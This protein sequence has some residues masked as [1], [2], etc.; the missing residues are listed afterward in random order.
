MAW[1]HSKD[2]QP[3]PSGGLR[4]RRLSSAKT[5][6]TNSSATERSEE[7]T[8]KTP[9]VSA[10]SDQHVY[11]VPISTEDTVSYPSDDHSRSAIYSMLAQPANVPQELPAGD[12]E[13]AGFDD[14]WDIMATCPSSSK[15]N[16]MSPAA[17]HNSFSDG[18]D[19][20]SSEHAL[21]YLSTAFQ[22][23]L[24]KVDEEHSLSLP[25]KLE[26]SPDFIKEATTSPLNDFVSHG[27]INDLI[28]GLSDP[29]PPASETLK[30]LPAEGVNE[31]ALLEPHTS[32]VLQ[33]Y[34]FT[35]EENS[36][37]CAV[38][39]KELLITS[40]V[41]TYPLPPSSDA[42]IVNIDSVNP[43]WSL[44]L[45]LYGNRVEE[46]EL[47]KFHIPGESATPFNV[48][49]PL[50]CPPEVNSTECCLGTLEFSLCSQEAEK[51]EG[52]GGFSF[53]DDNPELN[54]LSS[55]ELVVESGEDAIEKE[56][57]ELNT[58]EENAFRVNMEEE[59]LHGPL[60][61]STGTREQCLEASGVSS[62]IQ[63]T[64]AGE[65][66]GIINFVTANPELM[67]PPSPE[68]L[69]ED[70]E[71]F[72][73]DKTSD[74]HLP[75]QNDTPFNFKKEPILD[76]L[77]EDA[78]GHLLVTPLHS[79]EIEIT[80]VHDVVKEDIFE[81]EGD[82]AF[83]HRELVVT[84]S[85]ED[86][87]TRF[88]L[89]EV[90]PC[91]PSVNSIEHC[92]GTPEVSLCSQETEN[93][94]GAGN[95]SFID[96]NP[97]L[98]F[99]SSPELVVEV[100]EDAIEVKSRE[101]NTK[102]ENAILINTEE[103]A[104]QDPLIVSI[105]TRERCLEASDVPSCIQD[106]KAREV[107]GIINFVTA[108]PELMY[109]PSPELRAEDDEDFEEDKM[110]DLHLP[111]QNGL[112]LNIEKEPVLDS[113]VADT[114][115][116]L[117]VTPLYNEITE[118]HDVV[119]EGIFDSE[120]E[121]TFNHRKLAVTPS[122]DDSNTQNFTS[123]SMPVQFILN[124]DRNEFLQ[125][126]Q[127]AFSEP[128]HQSTRHSEGLFL[129]SGGRNNDEVYSSNSNVYAN[130][131][132]DEE[133]FAGQEGLPKFQ[134]EMPITFSDSPIFLDEVKSA[135]IV[136]SDAASPK[137]SLQ[138]DLHGGGVEENEL[139]KYHVPEEIRTPF[140]LEEE[141]VLSPLAVNNGS[142]FKQLKF[143]CESAGTPD[144]SVCNQETD[145]MEV[146]GS[147]S[148]AKASPE[149]SF[150]SS[151]ELVADGGEDTREKGTDEL[152]TKEENETLI[153]LEDE[154]LQGE[155]VVS[156][157]D[158][159]L[160]TSEFSLSSQGAKT[161]E[162]PEIVSFVTVSPELNYSAFPDLHAERDE[163]F[164]VDGMSDLLLEQKGLP[165]NLGKEPF[166]DPL[167]VDTAE[168]V[169]TSELL[170]CSEEVKMTEVH[171][172][173]KEVL[174]ESEDVGAFDHQKLVPISPDDD[175]T[176][177]N[178]INNSASAQ[179]ISDTSVHETSQAG[180]EVL[181]ESPH[182]STFHSEGIFFSSGGFNHDEGKVEVPFAGQ[183]GLSNSEDEMALTPL[184]TSIMLDEVAS[185]ENLTDNS[186]SS[187]SVPDSSHI[188]SLHNHE[189]ASSEASQEAIFLLEGSHT[190]SDEGINSEIFSLYSRSSSCVSE[191]NM[192]ETLRGSTSSEPP[193]DRDLSFE[194]RNPVTFPNV[195][196][197]ESNTN[198]PVTFEFILESNMIETLNDAEEATV[199]SPHEVSSNFLGTFVAPDVINGMKESDKHLELSSS[200]FAPVVDA[201]ESL[202]TG[203]G[204]S[205]PQFENE[206]AVQ[207]TP[208]S[209]KDVNDA[210]NSVTNAVGGP[211]DNERTSIVA[212]QD[213]DILTLHRAYMSPE[214]VSDDENSLADDY[215]SN[216]PHTV[217]SHFF[218]ENLS[219]ESQD[220]LSSEEILV[221]PDKGSNSGNDV[222]SAN[223]SLRSTVVNL[224]EPC[225]IDQEGTQQ[226]DE[227]MLGIEDNS[228]SLDIPDVVMADSRGAEIL[229][230][231]IL[232][233]GMSSFEGTLI[234]LD[235]DN[236]A[237]EDSPNNSGSFMHTAQINTQSLLGLQEGSFKPEEEI[238]INS[239]TPYEIDTEETSSS[240]RHNFSSASS[241][242]DISFMEAPQA[243]DCPIN[244]GREKVFPKDKE[245]KDGESKDMKEDV[246]DLDDG[247]EDNPI[248]IF[249]VDEITAALAPKPYVELYANDAS[250]RDPAMGTSNDYDMAIVSGFQ[251][252]K[253]VVAVINSNGNSTMSE[254]AD[255][256]YTGSVDDDTETL[257]SSVATD[258]QS[259]SNDMTARVSVEWPTTE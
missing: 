55:P 181:S 15:E 47:S 199:G 9:S 54:F 242:H 99:L 66:P 14:S 171:G 24:V 92:L 253:P 133:P 233:D 81:S 87:M 203:L 179:F 240:N 248:D 205:E 77:V 38:D 122:D 45:E 115:E 247:H 107:P 4:L 100:G 124:T 65:V 127:E 236:N 1:G 50:L 258:T 20:R 201:F 136:D 62:C 211:E 49:E 178:L 78:S 237:E 39:D 140:N 71:E 126:G 141:V 187:L 214:D 118:V 22:E 165:I 184:D 256:Q 137:L 200:S 105:C 36:T 259:I 25:E 28:P 33:L 154:A 227:T 125:G 110:S 239:V 192:P 243:Q 250:S 175:S 224:A 32:S 166:L 35:S 18:D 202:Q 21:S 113:P 162:V 148:F 59:A 213:G 27:S 251:Q 170:V 58:K 158:Q 76:S 7:K 95:F 117:L 219:P 72:K 103:E 98:G 101:L 104:L 70:D 112:P 223:S 119:K 51:L 222:S 132:E 31:K 73:E 142:L 52:A 108:N 64:K 145:E 17:P 37:S 135:A 84:H 197:T 234:S 195:D 212:L 114:A 93:L 167:V 29:V 86:S 91:P 83:N 3:A 60:I 172:V 159:S 226:H 130:V 123:D 221:Y 40:D 5:Y 13:E 116:H 190:S 74:L 194:E 11:Y 111:E 156:T 245:P 231:V 68:V 208:V 41:E 207:E 217:E 34:S 204:F 218:S 12:G 160:E 229:S 151:P 183:E 188:Q 56:S 26:L 143:I 44:L 89:E 79:E 220:P 249:G 63:D 155:P 30:D 146:A 238:A 174:S 255:G 164:K 225:G 53:V 8:Q 48:E 120:G 144:F 57:C 163:D 186:G 102:E 82:E 149:L 147:V 69:A 152:S 19:S 252:S 182:E 67:Y 191:I 161:T 168:D 193:N 216:L 139:S 153:I 228:G 96:D 61:V 150:L 131:V 129:S 215:A 210:G 109:P 180:Q 157:T 246:E 241:R 196:S 173:V 97:E 209:P 80:E 10:Y 6:M 94:E 42:A 177:Q 2:F 121:D 23:L 232:Y 169:V 206:F 90:L 106:A 230:S 257:P 254:L 75:E 46:T 128:L 185:A 244:S 189:Q 198:D 43:K 138:T 176:T 16:L 134:D 235:G 85:D 88:N